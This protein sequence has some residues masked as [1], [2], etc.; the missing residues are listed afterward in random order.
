M[1]QDNISGRHPWSV[2]P[3]VLSEATTV[4]THYGILEE[5]PIAFAS[6]ISL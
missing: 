2:F 4:I 6:S 1:S 5:V 3:L